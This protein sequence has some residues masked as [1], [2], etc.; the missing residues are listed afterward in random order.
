MNSG[1]YYIKCLVSDRIYIGCSKNIKIRYNIHMG[2]LRRNVHYN[3]ELQKD[4]NIYGEHQFI[5]E[6]ITLCSIEELRNKEKYYIDNL[7]P[8][9]NRPVAKHWLGKKFQKEHR[10][11]LR[12]VHIG[13]KRSLETKEKMRNTALEKNRVESLKKYIENKPD[14]CYDNLGNKFKTLKEAS[15]YHNVSQQTICD[16][17]KGRHFKTRKG[18][19]FYY[20]EGEK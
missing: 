5:L 17:L 4:F 2:E 6:I 13:S 8:Y 1:V 15:I 16:I 18:V 3:A 10:E 20:C 7:N 19:I 11:K 9:Y 14:I 12:E